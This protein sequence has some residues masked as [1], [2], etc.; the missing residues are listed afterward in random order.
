MNNCNIKITRM[1]ED[2]MNRMSDE[3]GNTEED[4][5]EVLAVEKSSSAAGVERKERN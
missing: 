2:T 3:D 4:E 5:P 1:S